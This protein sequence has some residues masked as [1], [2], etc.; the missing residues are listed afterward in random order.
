MLYVSPA[1]P[2][3]KVC[4]SFLDVLVFLVAE[5]ENN[6]TIDMFNR[7]LLKSFSLSLSLSQKTY[8]VD[9]LVDV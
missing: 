1:P 9:I 3:H 5:E 7:V 8:Q 2:E 6:V 4:F